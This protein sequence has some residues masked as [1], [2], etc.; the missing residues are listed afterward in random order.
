MCKVC[1]K[2]TFNGQSF[3]WC[4][5]L[6]EMRASLIKKHGFETGAG[7]VIQLVTDGLKLSS[8]NPN[9]IQARDAI[10]LADRI[11]TSGANQPEIWAA[12]SKRGMGYS[13]K[14][15]DSRTTTGVQRGCARRV[16]TP[17][18]VGMIEAPG[19]SQP[20]CLIHAAVDH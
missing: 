11:L 18:R 16:P 17:Q 1:R 4:S 3:S 19:F 15:P 10:L 20:Q 13:A 7:L 12:F 2:A 8:P 14:A 6:W 5:M 9:F